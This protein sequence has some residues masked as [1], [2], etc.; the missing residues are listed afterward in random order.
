MVNDENPTQ[1]AALTRLGETRVYHCQNDIT[2]ILESKNLS[3]K[4]CRN[5]NSLSPIKLFEF[6]SG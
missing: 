3:G 6:K 4:S 1:K 5:T 2:G